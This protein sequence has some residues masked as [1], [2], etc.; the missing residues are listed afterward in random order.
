LHGQMVAPGGS[1]VYLPAGALVRGDRP[2]GGTIHDVVF[3]IRG[4]VR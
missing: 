1:T 3:L 4:V 2:H